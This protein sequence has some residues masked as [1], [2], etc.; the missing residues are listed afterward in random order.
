MNFR[1]PDIETDSTDEEHSFYSQE[2]H[3]MS[4]IPRQSGPNDEDH[5][6]IQEQQSTSATL[7]EQKNRPLQNPGAFN[8]SSIPSDVYA[9]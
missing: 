7:Q 1:V 5:N 4:A 6:M 8:L 3:T 9:A 2:S